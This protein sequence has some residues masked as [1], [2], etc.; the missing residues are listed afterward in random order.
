MGGG[1]KAKAPGAL[2][3]KCPLADRPPVRPPFKRGVPLAL[4]GEAPGEVE[5]ER[6]A[7]FV[8]PTGEL[9]N[10]RI[11][12]HAGVK[13]YALSIHNTL[14]CRPA[15]KLSPGEWKLAIACCAPRLAKDLKAASPKLVIAAGKRSLQVL[16]GKAKIT[17][18]AGAPLKGWS[19]VLKERETKKGR[20]V[21][22]STP[23]TGEKALADFSGLTCLPVM[24]PAWHFR[25]QNINYL[26]MSRRHFERARLLSEGG[27]DEWKWPR[28][29]TEPG[30]PALQLLNAL[31]SAG[32]RGARISFD[33][34]TLG[35]NPFTAPIS[36]LGVGHRD[37]GS[38]TLTWES[39]DA[40]KY[41]PQEGVMDAAPGSI[42]QKC[43]EALLAI[44]TDNKIE[45]V[46]Q[47]GQYDRMGM[48]VRGIE[49]GGPTRVRLGSHERAVIF[50]TME[51]HSV[52]APAIQHN[53]S[54]IC[55]IETHAPRWKEEFQGDEKGKAKFQ[56]SD[57]L[58]LRPYNGKDNIMQSHVEGRGDAWMAE[59]H[60]GEELFRG[61]RELQPIAAEMTWRGVRISKKR[62]AWHHHALRTRMGRSDKDLLEIA[63]RMGLTKF[64]ID[65]GAHWRALF[66]GKFH[67]KPTKFSEVTGA[68]SLDESVL[69]PLITHPNTLVQAAAR[70][71]LQYRRWGTLDRN[72]VRG[73]RLDARSV[74]HPFWKPTGTVGQRWTSSRPNSQNIPKPVE[75][76]LPSGKRV[77]I[78]GGLRDM[79]IP[80]G[81]KCW[82]VEADY[83]QIELRAAAALAGEKRLLEAFAAYDA[84]EGPSPHNVNAIDIFGIKGRDVSPRE[85]TL[86]KNFAYN[87]IYGG[88]AASIHPVL[89]VDTPIEFSVVEKM[90]ERWN[91]QR[92]AFSRWHRALYRDACK[93]GFVEE[94]MSGRRRHFWTKPKTTEVYNFPVQTLA[95][96]II[97]QA[98]KKIAAEL[99][100]EFE[101][102]LFQVHDALVLDGPDPLRLAEILEGLMTQHLELGG[103]RM[104]F[105]VEVS[106][107]GFTRDKEKGLI[108][109]GRSSWA[110]NAAMSMDEIMK[111]PKGKRRLAA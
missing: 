66:F 39:Y 13:S 25:G 106:V 95:G 100:W 104:K 103:M 17:Q 87:V 79:F 76:R 8:G 53:L 88:D 97:N 5:E 29:I 46:A 44:L 22:L 57:P 6:G 7:Y 55:S 85:K 9:L 84:G 107:G 52:Y 56:S 86:A 40:G 70:A 50:D 63:H 98:I 78:H 26:P 51:A 101:G 34:E 20:V 49:F 54:L 30:E 77:V 105:P 99:D 59:T 33:I 73:L 92:P 35:D 43:R 12:P 36:C 10:E 16:T 18:W 37:H 111:L 83:S 3:S 110:P 96:W 67:V 31:R 23:K 21:E 68:P 91:A 109:H 38:V 24:H 19:F 4:L 45:K 42:G 93:N 72:H 90:I 32:R 81:E 2:C 60:R 69:T 71:G 61:Y 80:H 58:R 64:N 75:E 47:N 62:R 14:L 48:R 11:L 82:I 102:I 74:V 1:P 15:R 41:G 108:W 89:A 28:I 94:P 65:S 27:L